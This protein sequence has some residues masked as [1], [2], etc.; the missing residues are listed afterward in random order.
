MNHNAN[1]TTEPVTGPVLLLGEQGMLA[2]AWHALLQSRGI[3]YHAPSLDELDLTEPKTINAAV[4]SKYNFVINCAAWTDVDGAEEHED[5]ADAINSTGVS[6]LATRC[7]ETRATLV[8]YSTD[9]VFNGDATEPYHVSTPR[10]P[11]NAYGR[12][13]ARGE[14]FVQTSGCRYLIVRTSWLY[15]PWGNNFVRTM[16]RLGKEHDKLR[17]VHDQRGRPTSAEH[18]ARTSLALLDA[19]Q[20]GTCHVTDGGECTWYEFAKATVGKVNPKC[21]IEPCGSEEYSRPAKRP[22]YSVLDISETETVL[23]TMPSWQDNLAD[24]MRRLEPVAV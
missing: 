12:T 4:E 18:L 10:D 20:R 17:V 14:R 6:H 11:V 23:G 8:H 2:R 22:A 1:G 21:V 3:G 7:L 9:Y 24:V 15:A 16:A 13:K 19:G 5:K